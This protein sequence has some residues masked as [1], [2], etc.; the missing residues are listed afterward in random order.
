MR[1]TQLSEALDH[2]ATRTDRHFQLK[3]RSWSFFDC[4][5]AE[6]MPTRESRE[7]QHDAEEAAL[8]QQVSLLGPKRSDGLA[9]APKLQDQLVDSLRHSELVPLMVE[10]IQM[11][12]S[13]K[14]A[15]STAPSRYHPAQSEDALLYC[16]KVL[17]I[18]SDAQT[19]HTGGAS[20]LA[21]QLCAVG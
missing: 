10:F 4:C 2:V 11:Q 21:L 14:G 17:D 6:A 7:L 15:Q 12:R 18:I 8:Q 16:L 5:M 1:E 13:A 9:L 20:A 3:Q 19:P